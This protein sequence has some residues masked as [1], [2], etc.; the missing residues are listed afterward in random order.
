L[1]NM[2][3]NP[4]INT[5]AVLD[6][7]MFFGRR[8]LLRNIYGGLLSRQCISLIGL[9]HIGKSSLL[10]ALLRQELQNDFADSLQKYIFVLLDLREYNQKSRDDFFKDVSKSILAQA[11]KH[12]ELKHEPE[13]G[14]DAFKDLLTEIQKQGFHTVLLMDAFDNVARN[15]HFNW[16]FFS[17]LRSQANFG[18]VSYVTSTTAPLQDVCHGQI[19]DSPFFN[20]FDV[21]DV[22]VLDLEEA[23]ELVLRPSQN[24][25]L[26]FISDEVDWVIKLA[27]RHP[28]FIQQVC[29]Y[30][31]EEKLLHTGAKVD[32]KHIKNQAYRALEPHFNEIWERLPSDKQE[33]LKDEAR[34]V[35]KQTRKMPELS[36][37]SLFRLFVRNKFKIYLFRMTKEAVE[38]AL[39]KL[40]D[41]KE[42]GKCELANIVPS[43][44]QQSALSEAEK[45]LQVRKMLNEAFERM[46]G[47]G[48]RQ[49]SAADWRLYNILYYRYF[50]HHLKNDQISAR[51]E[52]TSTRQFFR[53]RTKAIDALFTILL[54]MEHAN[55]NHEEE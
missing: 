12:L 51:L 18:K 31:F 45:G 44:D 25:G 23:R 10:H 17:F 48:V 26:S 11:R 54:E 34:V 42:L 19:K 50:K 4:Y 2:L 24:L 21:Q 41:P 15:S 30:F 46:H 9:Q 43:Y 47:S 53:E 6:P 20:I 1:K 13:A 16:Q 36:E 38:E 7:T 32:R 14:S 52:F 40:N 29:K 8:A 22:G 28:F 35:N 27:G 37:S 3:H 33:Q 49:D 5:N 55:L 39:D